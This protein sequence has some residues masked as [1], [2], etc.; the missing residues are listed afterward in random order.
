MV[1]VVS[2][3]GLL[4]LDESV[5]FLEQVSNNTNAETQKRRSSRFISEFSPK[6]YISEDRRS[7]EAR[8][9]VGRRETT[10]HQYNALLRAIADFFRMKVE[11]SGESTLCC[12]VYKGGQIDI[13]PDGLEWDEGDEKEKKWIHPTHKPAWSMTVPRGYPGPR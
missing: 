1:K 13:W 5:D 3:G 7:M 2:G 11:N 10:Y 4:P 6:R 8:R 12:E 9:G